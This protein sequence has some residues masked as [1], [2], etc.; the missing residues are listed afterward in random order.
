MQP[1]LHQAYICPPPAPTPLPREFLKVYNLRFHIRI[2]KNMCS[3]FVS[4]TPV[5]KFSKQYLSCKHIRPYFMEKN[6][7]RKFTLKQVK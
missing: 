4:L 6:Y 2:S 7:F 3:D 5:V 1:A